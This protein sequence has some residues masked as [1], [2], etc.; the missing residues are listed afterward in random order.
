MTDEEIRKILGDAHAFRETA[1]LAEEYIRTLGARPDTRVPLLG[2]KG[3]PS[4]DV[5]MSLKTAKKCC[6][7]ASTLPPVDDL[8][9]DLLATQ[10]TEQPCFLCGF[11]LSADY[12]E[13]GQSCPNCGRKDPLGGPRHDS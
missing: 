7:C 5:W 1:E 11:Q 13:P 4:A 12:A 2:N 9:E 10:A 3:W 6:Y 8:V